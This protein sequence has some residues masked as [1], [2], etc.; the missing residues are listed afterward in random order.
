MRSMSKTAATTDGPRSIGSRPNAKS[1][2]HSRQRRH[3]PL[4]YPRSPQPQPTNPRGPRRNRP[5]RVRMPRGLRELR[6]NGPPAKRKRRQTPSQS[7]AVRSWP[8]RARAER[9]RPEENGAQNTISRPR[10]SP[11]I[12]GRYQRSDDRTRLP[13]EFQPNQDQENVNGRVEA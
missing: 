2:T 11:P 8:E 12:S 3:K 5:R 13:D 9:R 10:P 1:S 7:R 6:R 4:R